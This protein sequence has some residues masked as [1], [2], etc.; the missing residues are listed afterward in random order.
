MPAAKP[1]KDQSQTWNVR[2]YPN[3]SPSLKFIATAPEASHLALI[4]SRLR[5]RKCQSKIRFVWEQ[6]A[7]KD[8]RLNG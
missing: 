2:K 8:R 6:P 3:V 4:P 5:R 7:I 1:P